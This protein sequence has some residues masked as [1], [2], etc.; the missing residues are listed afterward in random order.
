MVSLVL[1]I[2]SL[3]KKVRSISFYAYLPIHIFLTIIIEF[4]LLSTKYCILFLKNA[5]KL[6]WRTVGNLK[7]L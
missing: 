3:E 5:I 7:M 4:Y 1:K 2:L 6:K